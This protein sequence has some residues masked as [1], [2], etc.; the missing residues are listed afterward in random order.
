MPQNVLHLAGTFKHELN[1]HNPLG[2]QGKIAEAY[3]E[4]LQH[5]WGSNTYFTPRHFKVGDFLNEIHAHK[6]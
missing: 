6:F 4:L 3:A 1:P 2:M 5:V